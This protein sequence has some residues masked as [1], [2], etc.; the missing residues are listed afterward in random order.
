[1]HMSLELAPTDMEYLP[2]G[3]SMQEAKFLG[4]LALL[5]EYFPSE[6]CL[7]LD[8]PYESE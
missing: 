4:A 7:Q 5:E 1:M 8:K 3:Q 2:M 6:H